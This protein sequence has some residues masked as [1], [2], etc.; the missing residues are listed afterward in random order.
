VLVNRPFTVRV[1]FFD[2]SGLPDTDIDGTNGY[3]GFQV[4]LDH[5]GGLTFNNRP[6]TAEI[7]WP[8]SS[9]PVESLGVGSNAWGDISTTMPPFQEST[10]TGIIVEADYT[11]SVPG[12]DSVRI[13][14]FPGSATGTVLADDS[15][16]LVAPSTT[17]PSLT[18]N[19][20]LPAPVPAMS[21]GATA[22]LVTLLLAASAWLLLFVA[23]SNIGSEKSDRPWGSRTPRH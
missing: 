8:Q 18:I 14:S 10:F 16:T 23:R 4:Q 9:L 11:C 6:G 20:F 19:C 3:P 15:T 21:P 13:K 2:I 1:S 17:D 5:S 7:L 12:V 22:F